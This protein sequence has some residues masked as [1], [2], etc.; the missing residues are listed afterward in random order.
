MAEMVANGDAVSAILS[1]YPT[2]S[3]AQIEFAERLR[4]SKILFSIP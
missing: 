2:L 3:K 4:I 1:A